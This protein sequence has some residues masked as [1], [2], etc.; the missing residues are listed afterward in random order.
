MELTK[1][2]EALNFYLHPQTFPVAVKMVSSA[3]EVPKKARQPLRDLGVPMPTCQGI[4][5]TR[6]YGWVMAMGKEDVYCPIGA[7]TLGFI[8]P[9][10]KF[11][12]GSFAV[13]NWL[14]DKEV[15][16]KVIENAQV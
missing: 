9:M 4:A 15:R 13:P 5:L 1:V 6:R 11:M 8:P 12:N 3:E 16:R 7:V 2:N 14:E 10:S